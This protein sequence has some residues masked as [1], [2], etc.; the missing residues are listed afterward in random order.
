MSSQSTAKI[1]IMVQ[2]VWFQLPDTE[3]FRRRFE[4][5]EAGNFQ[6]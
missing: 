2:V 4:Q 5:F 1:T 6:V 3:G